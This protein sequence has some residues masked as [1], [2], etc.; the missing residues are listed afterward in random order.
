MYKYKDG[1]FPSLV[2][3]MLCDIYKVDP[4]DIEVSFGNYLKLPHCL[5]GE[6]IE[7]DISIPIDEAGMMIINYAGS[8]DDSFI[9]FP[10]HNLLKVETDDELKL[11]LYDDFEGSIVI[12]SDTST[13]NK[14]H[15]PGI[16]DKVYPLSGL[17]LNIANTILTENFLSPSNPVLAFI[18]SVSIAVLLWVLSFSLKPTQFFLSSKKLQC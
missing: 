1:Y 4:S 7:K 8:W 18:I 15:G 14:D 12:L 2:L 9:H 10:I 16:F 11:R 13:R 3:R 6:F 17:H 5:Y